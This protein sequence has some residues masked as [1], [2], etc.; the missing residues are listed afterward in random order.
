MPLEQ[1]ANIAEVFGMLVVA[2]TLIF[3]TMQMR[4]NTKALQSSATHLTLDQVGIQIYGKL[5]SDPSLADLFV[6]GLD[7]PLC[8]SS[9]ETTRF[10][11][12]WQS[13]MFF[14]QNWYF[15][16]RV[17]VLDD[18][19]WSSWGKIMTDIYSTPGFRMF[20]EKRKYLFADD[21]TSY[22]ESE[23]FSKQ[24]MQDYRPLGTPIQ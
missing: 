7:D 11:A 16:W 2:I 4:Q 12:F 5:A 14:V 22:C 18:E 21:F 13:A 10:F 1:L 24:P 3:L 23:M 19:F 9:V 6:R 17:G 8:L 20:W 15:Q